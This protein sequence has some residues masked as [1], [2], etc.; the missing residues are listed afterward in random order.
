MVDAGWRETV[1]LL[2]GETVRVQVTFT[3]H[4]GVYLYHC[5]IL[6]HEGMRMMRNFRVTQGASAC[7]GTTTSDVSAGL[8]AIQND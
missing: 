4:P 6:E 2:P 7:C 3:R 8:A 1:L 5:H